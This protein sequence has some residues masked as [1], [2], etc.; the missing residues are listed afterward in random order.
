M[1]W[2]Q[3]KTEQVFW[4]IHY[5]KFTW[6]SFL[7]NLN[8]L[9][10]QMFIFIIKTHSKYANN[11]HG[12][13]SQPFFPS[14]FSGGVSFLP[15]LSFLFSFYFSSKQIVIGCLIQLETFNKNILALWMSIRV[16]AL[17][18]IDIVIHRIFCFFLNLNQFPFLYFSFPHSI[19]K[20]KQI[21]KNILFSLLSSCFIWVCPF[22]KFNIRCTLMVLGRITKNL[23]E[24][25]CLSA[26]E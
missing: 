4:C 14:F 6:F 12:R 13:W 24:Y 20:N 7:L 22:F 23:N 15:I 19:I 3:L 26:A 21:I 9:F 8:F 17:R 18:V 16:W 10:H 5:L 2:I 11:F 1:G 25:Y